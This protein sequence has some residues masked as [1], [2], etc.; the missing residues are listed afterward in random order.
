MDDLSLPFKIIKPHKANVLPIIISIPHS[1]T[2]FP[3]SIASLIY[4]HI[5]QKPED[6]DW[7]V[8]DLYQFASE[9]G[10]TIIQARASRYVIDLNRDPNNK[11]LY[12]DNRHITSLLPTKTFSNKDIYVNTLPAESDVAKRLEQYYWPYYQKITQLLQELKQDFPHVL[13]FDAHSIKRYVPTI[14]AE[15]FPSLILGNQDHKTADLKL[16]QCGLDSLGKDNL[17]SVSDNYPFKGGHITRYF[18]QPSKGIHALQLEMSQDIY[19]DEEIVKYNVAKA[20][21]VQ[22]LLQSLFYNLNKV[23]KE[24][25]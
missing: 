3:P 4:P 20:E 12:N 23:L 18:G 6:T 8:D 9:M 22:L 19:M 5:L 15:K 13:L 24:L 2:E 10:I 14:S 16:I 17:Y 7:Y 25:T 1:G 11:A 21:T